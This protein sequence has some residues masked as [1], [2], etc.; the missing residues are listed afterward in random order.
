MRP[1]PGTVLR[2][3]L[4]GVAVAVVAALAWV[5]ADLTRIMPARY[6]AAALLLALLLGLGCALAA[7]IGL[8]ARR[9]VT[10][11]AVPV[12]GTARIQLDL[13]PGALVSWLPL[14]RGA[15]RQHLPAELGGTG[16]L[17]LTRAMPHL[18]RVSARGGHELG[19][20]SLIF[21]DVF[22]LFHLRRTL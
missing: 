20:F 21:R 14:G 2:P 19:P 7:M 22:G 17:V 6:L 4:R 18:L 1:R 13:A 11:D 9:Q 8:R 5:L 12:G 16:D 10:D 15:V 3:T